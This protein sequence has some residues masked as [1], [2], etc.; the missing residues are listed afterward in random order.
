MS[1]PV[2]PPQNILNKTWYVIHEKMSSFNFSVEK[3][4]FE[5]NFELKQIYAYPQNKPFLTLM[6]KWK[7]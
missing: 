1:I 7:L 6:L 4:I 3:R 2:R 5:S